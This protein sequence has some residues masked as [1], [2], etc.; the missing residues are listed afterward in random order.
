MRDFD[1]QAR[2]TPS[3]SAVPSYL[4]NLFR[5]FHDVM[6]ELID[7]FDPTGF[8]GR[9]R[10]GRKGAWMEN[11]EARAQPLIQ[12]GMQTHP[13]RCSCTGAAIRDA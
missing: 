4:G 2:R 7:S 8:E 3:G 9:I 5:R 1:K 11:A 13:T 12:D 6:D 10:D